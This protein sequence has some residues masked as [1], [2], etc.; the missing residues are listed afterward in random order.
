MGNIEQL[1]GSNYASWKEKLEITLAL[2]D[3][4]YALHN[5]PLI[6]PR[7]ENENYETL[8]KEYDEVKAKWDISNRKFLMII[9]S[10]IIDAI[11]GAVPETQTARE[12]LAK[13]EEQFKGSSK[14]Y[15]TTL[16]K[17][18]VNE[19]YDFTGNLREHV[20]KKCHVAFKLKS[21]E[22]KISEGLLV[23]FIMSSLPQE[24]SPFTI[25]YNAMKIKWGI[26]ELIAMCVQEEERLKA[27]R[28]DHAN[29]FK[30]SEKKRYKKFKKE[31]LKPKPRNP[32]TEE[33]GKEKDGCYF[34]GKSGHRQK[35]CIGFMRWLS[36]K[37]TD[38]ISFVDESLNIDYAINSW[39]IDSGATIHVANSLQGFTMRR[40]LRRGERRIK[41]ANGVE[42]EVKAIGDFILTLHT[43]FKF[44]LHD[45]LY[46]PSMKRN[47]ISVSRLDNGGYYCTFGNNRCII[48]H[49]NKE[50]GLAD[51]QEQL[52]QISVCDATYNVDSSL[53]AN[54]STKR[55]HNDN[56]TSSKLWH[57]RLGHISRGRI[58]R[59]IKENI[60]YPLDF[61]DAD[62]DHCIDCIKGKYSKQIKKGAN[63]S[64]GVL[65]IIHTDICGPFNVK[66]VDGFDLFI[67]FTDDY[68]RY[69]YIYPIKER[70]E[71]LDKFKIFKAEI[72]I[73]RSDRGGE[74]YGRHTTYGQI[75]R[76][77]ARF[78]QENGIK[79]QYS[80]PSEP[81]QNGVAE[82]R[83]RTLMDMVRSM[84]S[85]SILPVKLWMEALQTA[86]HILN[87]V[88]SKLV[89]KTPKTA[90][91]ILNRVPSKL[92]TKFIE[93]RHDVFLE[94]DIIKGSMT[95]R[96]VVLEEKLNYVPMPLIEE[97]VFSTH[98]RVTPSIERNND[99]TS[100][101]APATTSSS[102]S[103]DENNEDTQQP[104]VVIDEQNNEPVRRSQRVRKSAIPSDYVTYMNK[105]VNEPMS[106][107]V[108]EPILDIDP[109]SFKEAMKSEHSSEWLNAMKDEMKSMSTNKVWDLIEI[110]EG[111][112]TVGCKW[113]YKTKRDPKGN[114]ERIIM[115]LVA[116]YDLELYQMDV[117][118]AFLNGDLYEDVYMAQPEGF[119]TKGKEHMGCH[120]N[121][122]IYGL[123][124]ASR[125]WYLK[126]DQIIR[127]FGFKENKKDNCIY[128]NFKETSP[129]PIMKGDKYEKFQCPKNEYEAAQMKS[130]PYAS[131][132]GSIMYAQVCTR[133][134]LAFVT[135]M[136]GRYQSNPGLEHWKL[137]KKTLR[138]LQGTKDLMLTYRKSKNLEVVGCSDS[139]LAGCV[140]DK[141]STSGYIFTLA[142]GAISWKSSE[143]RV[144]ASSTMQAEYVACYEATGQ[145]IW[146]KNFILGLRVV[147]SISKPLKLY[148][149]NK[150]AV[151]YASS[152]KSSASAKY[153]DI[154]YHVVKEMI[155]D[156]TISV[157]YINT[158]LMLA[159][160]LTKGLTPVVFKEHVAGMGL[161][162]K[163][164][165]LE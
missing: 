30:H 96:E 108:N 159:D 106:E 151:Y 144:T 99:A 101:E 13:V 149:D 77:F 91:H 22:M 161:V 49:D 142:R 63:R 134:D 29:L 31:F 79:A 59:L 3:I 104:Q 36:K 4:D 121:K 40:T 114:I 125:Q 2:L 67:T 32:Y 26:D 100:A 93:T 155:Q 118:T 50:V 107:E 164:L 58:E 111:A 16:I 156:Q 75:P 98:T 127:Q 147:D 42:T 90:A 145:A 109:I 37:G 153:I 10:S 115:A 11:R 19:K 48:M 55:K 52:Y 57:Y 12:Y 89:P 62:I 80:A 78:L 120:L 97:P 61:S 92:F 27:E 162:E 39:W 85:H 64:M 165:I 157:E 117:K 141:K 81:Q 152:N 73:V 130:I 54:V 112:K 18:L 53:N 8:K 132:V 88:P 103:N 124:Q 87:R 94:N 138:Y 69:G 148:C 9:K 150:P 28:V 74:Y 24:F 23:H 41:V 137:A 95:P 83:N 56:E 65:E 43:G 21:M 154:K 126:F 76:P 45:V 47:L 119:V 25:D 72:K 116:H 158:K 86:A 46:V 5:N 6:E 44:Q 128:A 135:G 102:I 136:L 34:C 1:N 60:L 146:L 139:D 33:K 35:D 84:L 131:A 20:M 105:E 68:S 15:A 17:R 14:V 129:A 110:P 133:P 163:P 70:S 51:G 38:V 143:Q 123:K 71:A 66:S 160:P 122:S 7:P 140:D 113:V 82:R